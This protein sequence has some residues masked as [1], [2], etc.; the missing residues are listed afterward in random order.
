MLD[1]KKISKKE[2]KKILIESNSKCDLCRALGIPTNGVGTRKVTELV[3]RF[4]LNIEHFKRNIKL[5]K[6]ERIIDVCPCGKEYK[7][8]VGSKKNDSK[9]C[10]VGCY[11]KYFMSG[12]NHPMWKPKRNCEICDNKLKKNSTRFCSPTCRGQNARNEKFKKIE[13]GELK[14]KSSNGNSKNRLYKLYL[15]KKNGHRC[16]ICDLSEWMGQP[17]PLQLDHID[18]DSDN[19]KLYNIRNV[20]PNCHAQTPTYCGKNKGKGKRKY[21]LVDYHNGKKKY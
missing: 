14:Y 17:I 21:R 8:L 6:Y 19:D 20:C 2:F 1:Y 3:E 5:R 4:G 15:I 13:S 7:R 11:H 9:A 18:G 10:S 16:M 12:E